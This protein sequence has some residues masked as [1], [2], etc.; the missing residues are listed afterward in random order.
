MIDLDSH[1]FRKERYIGLGT[2]HRLWS[3]GAAETPGVVMM[4]DYNFTAALAWSIGGPDAW[5]AKIAAGHR[6]TRG[7]RRPETARNGEAPD[8]QRPS[9]EWGVEEARGWPALALWCRVENVASLGGGGSPDLYGAVPLPLPTKS[10]A[11]TA[12]RALP[13]LPIWPGLAFNTAFYALLWWLGFASV[14]TIKHNRRYR[15][16]LCPA[17]RYDL[18]ADY[19]KGCSE[20][21]WGRKD[22]A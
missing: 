10:I 19:S 1:A 8:T 15:R 14:R 9:P 16:G 6:W 7:P 3:I 11:D 21:G 12:F 18:K 22:A 17:C 20:C 5:G 13:L 2:V 4:D